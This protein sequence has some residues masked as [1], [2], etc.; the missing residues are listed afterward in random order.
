MIQ[1]TPV[2]GNSLD[3]LICKFV[4][5]TNR[6]PQIKVLPPAT[7]S[8]TLPANLRHLLER[9]KYDAPQA[10]W[11]S[12]I[13][14]IEKDNNYEFFRFVEDLI[15][16][17]AID[18]LLRMYDD[19]WATARLIY[20]ERFPRLDNRTLETDDYTSKESARQAAVE[21]AKERA[22]KGDASNDYKE[23][24]ITEELKKEGLS[25]ED[26]QRGY[27]LFGSDLALRAARI[28]LLESL[29]ILEHI[30]RSAVILPDEDAWLEP[31]KTRYWS[32]G[33]VEIDIAEEGSEDDREEECEGDG[34]EDEIPV[35]KFTTLEGSFTGDEK[36]PT[37]NAK[38]TNTR[39]FLATFLKDAAI[40]TAHDFSQIEYNGWAIASPL[41][42]LLRIANFLTDEDIDRTADWTGKMAEITQYLTYLTVLYDPEKHS[43]GGILREVTDMLLIHVL[44]ENYHYSNSVLNLA[45][46]VKPEAS[47]RL[48][49]TEG[50]AIR[51]FE[52]AT[53]RLRNSKT[54]RRLLHR[55]PLG[56]VDIMYRLPTKALEA[57]LAWFLKNQKVH[58]DE[59][60]SSCHWNRRIHEWDTHA[61]EGIIPFGFN[62]DQV[63]DDTFIQCMRLGPLRTSWALKTTCSFTY[64]AKTDLKSQQDLTRQLWHFSRFRGANR[65]GLTMVL[66]AFGSQTRE[67]R[68]LD[69]P[70]RKLVLPTAR[71]KEAMR[72]ASLP[73]G[74]IWDSLKHDKPQD[75]VDSF[76]GYVFWHSMLVKNN[77]MWATKLMPELEQHSK[78]RFGVLAAGRPPLPTT[79]F[80]GPFI[81]VDVG[82]V[83]YIAWMFLKRLKSIERDLKTASRLY[84]RFFMTDT[85][86]HVQW[87]REDTQMQR[88]TYRL[89]E[90][91]AKAQF[92]ERAVLDT[93]DWE[94][95]L[96]EKLSHRSTNEGMLEPVPED[97]T[98]EKRIFMDRVQALVHDSS[99]HACFDKGGV[100]IEELLEQL[101]RDVGGPVSM[102][103]FT[104]Q[105]QAEE[106]LGDLERYGRIR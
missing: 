45:F 47:T 85:L 69:S 14:H 93:R 39:N 11:S 4:P 12:I 100:T 77:E 48:P 26:V 16:H 25:W 43:F 74:L 87:G 64:D 79:N 28:Q 18:D 13:E 21:K 3:P 66:R 82:A 70:Y 19:V 105:R 99:G 88:G 90:R 10:L 106:Y 5:L 89:S 96:L 40:G 62:A 50:P 6:P 59:G 54:P 101:N 9:V 80:K 104:N 51:L 24:W 102:I 32:T 34:K 57:Y 63:E 56:V 27:H 23:D 97:W 78:T 71:D 76:K 36:N 37:A 44:Y 81:A 91:A 68:A 61:V 60:S 98:V 29:G 67:I 30:D 17:G 72:T 84:P 1:F 2:D 92:R 52:I 53:A 42:Q 73:A 33:D 7:D 49:P 15:A 46:D 75:D 86:A 83:R 58:W 31:F 103:S 95:Q 94:L 35:T 41:I 8:Q 20:G 38:P 65:A 22:W 55:L